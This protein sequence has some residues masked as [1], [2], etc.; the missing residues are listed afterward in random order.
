MAV[1]LCGWSDHAKNG[2]CSSQNCTP[3]RSRRGLYIQLLE[4]EG[5]GRQEG[6]EV[7]NAGTRF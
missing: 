4:Q 5:V 7:M 2:C 6:Q 1:S 3:G